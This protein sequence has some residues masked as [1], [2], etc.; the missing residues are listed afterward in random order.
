[1]PFDD[2]EQDATTRQ[3]FRVFSS[4]AFMYLGWYVHS[5][6]FDAAQRQLNIGVDFVAGE[7]FGYA[8]VTCTKEW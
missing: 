7:R 1:V 3:P 5:V 8:G 4:T 2:W 6:D